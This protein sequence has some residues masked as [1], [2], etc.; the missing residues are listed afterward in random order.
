[1][2]TFVKGALTANR[3]FKRKIRQRI[4]M[5]RKLLLVT[6]KSGF[7]YDY[8]SRMQEL[9]WITG[10]KLTERESADILINKIGWNLEQGPREDTG[11]YVVGMQI[12]P[13]EDDIKDYLID[14]NSYDEPSLMECKE[15]LNGYLEPDMLDAGQTIQTYTFR[16]KDE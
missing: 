15:G 5:Y 14:K 7:Y 6:E 10:D 12:M 4:A 8:L 11:T 1:M 2:K 16:K 13:E 3:R 9:S